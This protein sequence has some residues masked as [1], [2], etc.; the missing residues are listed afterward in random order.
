M[1]KKR[2]WAKKCG[3]LIPSFMGSGWLPLKNCSWN[4]PLVLGE[5]PHTLTTCP[6]KKQTPPTYQGLCR[7]GLFPYIFLEESRHLLR[8]FRDPD[9]GMEIPGSE[10][11]RLGPKSSFDRTHPRRPRNPFG[12]SDARRRLK[13]RHESRQLGKQAHF[14]GYHASVF[15]VRN[16]KGNRRRHCWGVPDTN[17][18]RQTPLTP[19]HLEG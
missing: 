11:G 13:S 2:T 3:W 5:H 8:S 9:C 1:E 12:R 17:A 10:P 4:Q 15:S 6:C 19:S 7:K 14:R 18:A 16:P